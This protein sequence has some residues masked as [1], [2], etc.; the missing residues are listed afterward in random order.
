MSECLLLRALETACTCVHR[1]FGMIRALLRVWCS[2]AKAA[3]GLAVSAAS[4]E[5]VQCLERDSRVSRERPILT[6]LSISPLLLHPPSSH[7]LLDRPYGTLVRKSG[8]H[9]HT[10]RVCA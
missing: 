7:A 3:Q 10:L 5:R 8:P 4:T 2:L 1:G 9:F 6:F